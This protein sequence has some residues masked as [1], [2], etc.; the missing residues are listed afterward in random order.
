MNDLAENIDAFEQAL[1]A[2]IKRFTDDCEMPLCAVVGALNLA[3]FDIMRQNESTVLAEDDS[4][5]L[6]GFDAE[7]N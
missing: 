4:D 7:L 2:L 3:A 5:E 6:N 1:Y